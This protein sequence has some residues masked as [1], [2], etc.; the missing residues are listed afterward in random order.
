[1]GWASDTPG[2]TFDYILHSI[3][4]ERNLGLYNLNFYSNPRVDEIAETAST[5][6]DP[7]KRLKLVREGFKLAMD[8]LAIIPLHRQKAIYGLVPDVVWHPRVDER[9]RLEEMRIK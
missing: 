6:I 9:L 7:E 4:N 3:D 2:E 8:D 5:I 1:M